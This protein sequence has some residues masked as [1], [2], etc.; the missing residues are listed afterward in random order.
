MV[1]CKRPVEIKVALKGRLI[2]AFTLSTMSINVTPVAVYMYNLV[3]V[4]V[5]S[6]QAL[7]MFQP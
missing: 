4:R 7:A 1:L 6:S 2:A 5:T 3:Y